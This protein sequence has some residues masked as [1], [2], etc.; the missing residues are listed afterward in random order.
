MTTVE[1]PALVEVDCGDCG[2]PGFVSFDEDHVRHVNGDA[3]RL[4]P[5]VPV[6][7]VRDS[8]FWPAVIA[9]T[10]KW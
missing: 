3:C 1:R 9:H 6:A 10:A 5:R 2:R 7:R 4:P 8:K